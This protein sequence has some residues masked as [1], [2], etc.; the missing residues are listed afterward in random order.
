MGFVPILYTYRY[1]IPQP[2]PR[3]RE[4]SPNSEFTE[5]NTSRGAVGNGHRTPARPPEVGGTACP[6]MVW[7]A[8]LPG[9]RHQGL[10]H[11]PAKGLGS[12]LDSKSGRA[13]SEAGP[14]GGSADR[15][16]VGGRSVS[17]RAGGLKRCRRPR[18]VGTAASKPERT[19]AD[20]RGSCAAACGSDRA[21]VRRLRESGGG[22][23]AGKLTLWRAPRSDRVFPPRVPGK[24]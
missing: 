14:V 12:E 18:C 9:Y 3:P 6:R 22:E 17:G 11:S 5:L 15:G 1:R 19:C 7:M 2:C 10:E 24:R 21:G 23:W 20:G 16:G 4:P 8:I 13:S